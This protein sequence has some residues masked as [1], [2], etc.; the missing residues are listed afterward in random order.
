MTRL[1]QCSAVNAQ[2]AKKLTQ[3]RVLCGT[4]FSCTMVHQ[5]Y[6][7]FA[8][9]LLEKFLLNS[10]LNITSPYIILLSRIVPK[11]ARINW[12]LC[13]MWEFS[14]LFLRQVRSSFSKIY[15]YY[16]KISSLGVHRSNYFVYDTSDLTTCNNFVGANEKKS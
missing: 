13:A 8:S 7:S 11:V 14:Q 3:N 5:K 6:F 10:Y 15:L 4:A 9:F 16:Y 1:G 2:F 12:K